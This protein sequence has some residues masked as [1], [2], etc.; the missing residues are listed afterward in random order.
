MM[1]DAGTH[2]HASAKRSPE[3]GL[4]KVESEDTVYD[5]DGIRAKYIDRG[6]EV[7]SMSA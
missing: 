5:A 3:G 2:V 4:L 7:A 1:H 6:V